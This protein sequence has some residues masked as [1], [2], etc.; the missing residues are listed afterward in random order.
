MSALTYL[1]GFIA[2]TVDRGMA[3][4]A[5]PSTKKVLVLGPPARVL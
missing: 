1:P 5:A 2:N 3:S 4:Q